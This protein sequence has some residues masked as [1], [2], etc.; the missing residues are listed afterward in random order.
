VT[1]T[2]SASPATPARRNPFA[3]GMR[4]ARR[5]LHLHGSAL[6]NA[7]DSVRADDAARHARQSAAD[8]VAVAAA[9]PPQGHDLSDAPS[10][11]H[12]R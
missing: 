8:A 7:A 12:S 4:A 2:P 5:V 9:R 10:N 11:V 3:V 6:G 1:P